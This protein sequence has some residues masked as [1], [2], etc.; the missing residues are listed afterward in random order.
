MVWNVY[1]DFILN[2]ILIR[3]EIIFL[4]F[5]EKFLCKDENEIENI[6]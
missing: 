5:W 3:K 6:I 1:E 2:N 4:M